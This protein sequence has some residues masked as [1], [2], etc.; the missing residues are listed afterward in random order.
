MKVTYYRHMIMMT[1]RGK[2]FDKGKLVINHK[3]SASNRGETRKD[4]PQCKLNECKKTRKK[5]KFRN[6]K[7]G[8]DSYNN[9]PL[10]NEVYS[11]ALE[12]T[13][14]RTE[15][16]QIVAPP[17]STGKDLLQCRQDSQTCTLC[18]TCNCSS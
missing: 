14:Q 11:Y 4:M 2:N 13:L 12:T 6:E 5:M 17:Y 7:M 9:T 15:C 1:N 3:V 8:K 16:M 10:N 18:H